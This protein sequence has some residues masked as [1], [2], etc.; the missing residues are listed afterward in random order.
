[1]EKK[2]T[3]LQMLIDHLEERKNKLSTSDDGLFVFDFCISKA[4]DLLEKERE[5][6]LNAYVNG[7]DNVDGLFGQTKSS[8]QYYIET[9]K[10]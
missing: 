2:K 5:V 9:Y 10:Q 7:G 3:P 8:E 1:M 6:I 4:T